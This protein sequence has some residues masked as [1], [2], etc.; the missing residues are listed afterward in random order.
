VNLL[1]HKVT[2]IIGNPQFKFNVWWIEVEANCYGRVSQIK[3]MRSTKE[4]AENVK[5]GDTF[6]A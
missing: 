1:D 2:K 3:I 4:E 6:Q 5:V